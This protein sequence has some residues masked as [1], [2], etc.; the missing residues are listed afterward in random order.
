MT[1]PSSSPVVV[2]HGFSD[3]NCPTKGLSKMHFGYYAK[4]DKENLLFLEHGVVS[5]VTTHDDGTEIKDP[6]IGTNNAAEYYSMIMLHEHVCR[7]AE[8]N[9][10][11]PENIKLYLYTDSRLMYNQVVGKWRVKNDNLKPLYV[12]MQ[13]IKQLL[14]YEIN[15]IEREEN[16]LANN[17]AADEVARDTFNKMEMKD[18]IY[19]IQKHAAI[20]Q[21]ATS[22]PDYEF[23]RSYLFTGLPEVKAQLEEAI[24]ESDINPATVRACLTR[25]R[26]EVGKIEERI[27]IPQEEISRNSRRKIDGGVE[28][29]KQAGLLASEA[30]MF[31]EPKHRAMFNGTFISLI[32]SFR[33]AH[34]DVTPELLA[35]MAKDSIARDTENPQQWLKNLARLW[36]PINAEYVGKAVERLK[37]SINFFDDLVVQGDFD[38]L[39]NE[40]QYFFTSLFTDRMEGLEILKAAEGIVEG[41][42][43]SEENRSAVMDFTDTFEDKSVF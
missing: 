34:R 28:K 1:T 29:H 37:D 20:K 21:C 35:S 16:N 18:N 23:V 36:N 9:S 5:H 41:E 39:R 30:V 7:W 17:L 14:P 27:L 4:D 12:K 38:G 26:Q 15:W 24:Q 22:F 31:L 10:V 40:L 11:K 3:S 13:R 42:E 8:Q 19:R 6:I 32:T 2:I 33:K 43:A 25:F